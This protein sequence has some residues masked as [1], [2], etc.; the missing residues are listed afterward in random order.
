MGIGREERAHQAKQQHRVKGIESTDEA[1]ARENGG[2]SS[3][4]RPKGL[5]QGGGV[6]GSLSQSHAEE[7]KFSLV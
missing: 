3:L 7:F 4:T 5:Y 1:G 6:R 2:Q